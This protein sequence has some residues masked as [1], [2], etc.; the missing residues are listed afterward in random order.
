MTD[1]EALHIALTACES[2]A[3]SRANM[4]RRMDENNPEYE[5][6][7]RSRRTY[8]EAGK[9]INKLIKEKT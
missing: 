1:L 4:L 7:D 3:N 6:I 8:A 9:V 2:C 5:N